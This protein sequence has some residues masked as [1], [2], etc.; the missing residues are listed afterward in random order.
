MTILERFSLKNKVALVTGGRRGIGKAIVMAFAE[1]GADIAICDYVDENED[2]AKL[3]T[4]L[5]GMGRQCLTLKADVSKSDQVQKM[6]DQ[7]MATYGKIDILVNNAGI[8]P[9][10]PPIADLPEADW[11]AVIDINL[12]GTYLCTQAVVKTMIARK[13]GSIINI[14]SVEGLGT[15]RRA[16]SPYGASKAGVVMLTRG[17]AWDLAKHNVR[18]NGIAPGYIRTVMTRMM[19][20]AENPQ[21]QKTMAYLKTQ[22]GIR[23]ENADAASINKMLFQ[24]YIP[25][26][27][28][29]EPEEI[30]GGALYLASDAASYVTGHT[31]V[32]DGGLLA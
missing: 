28:M 10:T 29:A 15:V 21:Y 13:S 3:T 11:D 1:A 6:V 7:V 24:S 2:F 19:W 5:K 20:D 25:M 17:L 14:A 26:A 16:S 8:S 31:P 27:R 12:K 22:Y 18:V 9:G 4:E 32:I 30:A 23:L